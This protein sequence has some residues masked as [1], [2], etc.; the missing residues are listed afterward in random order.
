MTA[1][2]VAFKYGKKPGAVELRALDKVREVYGIRR[3][4][5]NE[6]EN[7]IRL[8]YDRTRLNDDT[9]AALLRRAGVDIGEKLVL[10]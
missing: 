10:A 8:E 3:L 1:I 6:P 4:W 2:E 9:V 7:V 5:F